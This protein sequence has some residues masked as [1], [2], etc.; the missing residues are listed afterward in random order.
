MLEQHHTGKLDLPV[1]V[2]KL[3]KLRGL[4]DDDFLLVRRGQFMKTLDASGRRVTRFESS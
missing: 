2:R 3:I 1:R 4:H